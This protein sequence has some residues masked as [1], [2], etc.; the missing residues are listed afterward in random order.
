MHRRLTI[1]V[2]ILA[3]CSGDGTGPDANGPTVG[4]LLFVR[5]EFDVV[6]GF[7]TP[8]K[9]YQTI[10]DEFHVE[11]AEE[12][13]GTPNRPTVSRDGRYLS[14]QDLPPEKLWVADR[15]T[16]DRVP[17]TP[18]FSKDRHP[19]FSPDGSRVVLVRRKGT[20]E[21]LITVARDGSDE[22]TVLPLAPPLGGWP[23]WSPDGQWIVWV[24]TVPGTETQVE[25]MRID[26]SE[27]HGI[28]FI[29]NSEVSVLREPIWSPD[30]TRI[31]FIERN[32]DGTGTLYVTSPEGAILAQLTIS[33][34]LTA[35]RPA[36]SPDG[37]TIAYCAPAPLVIGSSERNEIVLWTYG[38]GVVRGISR[39]DV[40]DCFPTWGR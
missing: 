10:D 38:T 5:H 32:R 31:A 12:T 40:S 9:L 39:N 36:W 19:A 29:T 25:V 34:G 21:T 1:V 18:L 4:T 24:R 23:D 3:A 8:G 13:P 33:T 14:W 37:K 28:S 6:N 30:G 15:L 11:P 27:R 7:D 35:H 17:I 2:L 20:F 26:G 22:Q 16:G